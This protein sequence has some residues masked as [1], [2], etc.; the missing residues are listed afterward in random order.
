MLHK[1]LRFDINKALE[2]ATNFIKANVEEAGASGVVIGISGGIDSSV[3]AALAVKA[4]GAN[5]VRAL[6]LPETESSRISFYLAGKV[7]SSL[8][9]EL[10]I[11]DITNIVKEFLKST[12]LNYQ[13]APKIVKG[14]I[15]V[16]TR[17]VVLYTIANLENRL[18]L[19]TSDRSE[20]LIGYFTKWG[21]SS[22]DLYPNLGLYKTQVIEL[23]RYLGLPNEVVSR[24]PTP[25]LWPGHKAEDE[26]GVS[27][28]EIDLVLYYLFDE[29]SDPEKVPEK[30][31]VPMNIVRR[32]IELHE[33]S[34]H[35]RSP[36]KAPF[37][38]FKELQ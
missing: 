28:D 16:R 35:K 6:F 37:M 38:T 22:A 32:I 4:L 7:A 21:D 30:A 12:G 15:K 24:D 8:G 17:T 14:N 20:W 19:G 23:G 1:E 2:K 33:K 10:D 36:L 5:K 3:A 26:L 13:S 9:L 27:Y 25:D 11:I 34:H 18:V 29:R 31:G